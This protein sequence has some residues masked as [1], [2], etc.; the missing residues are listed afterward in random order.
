MF[1]RLYKGSHWQVLF[2][3]HNLRRVKTH[4][5]RQSEQD[6]DFDLFMDCSRW[7]VFLR[8]I[9]LSLCY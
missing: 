6:V 1:F 7:H 5:S 9:G 8:R 3:E 2:L 4:L